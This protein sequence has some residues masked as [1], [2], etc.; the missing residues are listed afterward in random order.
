[1][2]EAYAQV[3][4]RLLEKGE[5]PHAAV[6]KVHESLKASG[7]TALFPKIARAFERLMHKKNSRTAVRLFVATEGDSRNAKHEA[8]H[9]LG[10]THEHMQVVS[11]Q[12]LIGG[13]RV[14]AGE[15][16]VDMSYKKALLSIFN[17]ATQ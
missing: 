15:K 7:R 9:A 3:L 8:E 6:Q 16:L 13:W 12:S 11:D 1:M 17:R 2:P 5:A 4:N 10:T 14:E